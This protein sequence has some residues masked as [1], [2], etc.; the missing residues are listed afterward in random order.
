MK[1]I[2]TRGCLSPGGTPSHS[3]MTGGECMNAPLTSWIFFFPALTELSWGFLQQHFWMW[4]VCLEGKCEVSL[5]VYPFMRRPI[6][7]FT[8]MFLCLPITEGLLYLF[9]GLRR[10]C[11]CVRRISRPSQWRW[12]WRDTTASPT[13]LFHSHLRKSGTTNSATIPPITKKNKASAFVK[14]S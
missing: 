8:E 12:S 7:P 11:V 3:A 1:L 6:F 9:S 2:L 14:I 13:S 10:S 4:W 5:S